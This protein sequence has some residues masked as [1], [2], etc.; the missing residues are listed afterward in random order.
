MMVG[1]H[2]LNPAPPRHLD[3][4]VRADSGV[5]GDNELDAL[6]E[7]ALQPRQGDAM[8]LAVPE[9]NVVLDIGSGLA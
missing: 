7:P 8:P 9:G 3:R 2:R 1:D 4:L 6:G 5:T